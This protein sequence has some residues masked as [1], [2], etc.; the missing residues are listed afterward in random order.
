[1]QYTHIF[2]TLAV[3]SGI[4]S[5]ASAQ[6][7]T[8][9]KS[10][11]PNF[12]TVQ[13]AIDS[14]DPDPNAGQPNIIQITDSALYDEIIT[15]DVPVT[16]DGTAATRPVLAVQ[17][18]PASAGANDGLTVSIAAAS[19][20]N[21]V[22]LK[23]LIV[24]PSTTTPPADDGIIS[25]GQ[26]LY[27]ELNNVVVTANNGSNVPL[28]VD[29]MSQADT[30]GAIFFGDDGVFLGSGTVAGTGFEG[31]LK[32]TVI[33]H[34]QAAGAG[35]DGLVCSGTGKSYTILDGCVISFCSRLGIQAHGDFEIAASKTDKAYILSNR[36]F[37]GLWFAG[38][39]IN[40]RSISGAV[41]ANSGNGTTEGFGIEHQNA[42]AAG[43]TVT[44]S[45][46]VNNTSDN[47]RVS[48]VGT[49]ADVRLTRVTLANQTTAT[50]SALE[51]D[52]GATANIFLTDCIV[53]GNGSGEVP[54]TLLH[55]GTG[56]L[57]L[58]GTALV[59]AGPFALTTPTG[60]TGPVSGTPTTTANPQFVE[61]VNVASASFYDVANPA[62]ATASSTGGPLGGG[63]DFVGG[64]SVN[65]WSVY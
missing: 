18:N 46:I 51:I 47:I 50:Q 17:T 1:M 33:T 61:T 31:V 58:S 64:S 2:A 56:T 52:A 36:G 57:T 37:A 7:V 29:G 49:T 54:N 62:Y 34:L 25:L 55:N 53:A 21:S 59:T 6:T 9:A 11:S 8:V 10:G 28:A 13:A 5:V 19:T 23:N 32:D 3:L 27:L 22:F 35:H 65:D 63:A 12:A 41:I 60:G 42:G 43:M 44:D 48:N 39:G 4:T 24:I 40:K 16:I 26:N 14:F 30:T 45:I 20:S 15:V 38:G